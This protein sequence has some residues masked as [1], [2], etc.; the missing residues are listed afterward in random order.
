[1]KFLAYTHAPHLREPCLTFVDTGRK[2]KIPRSYTK[3]FII[4]KTAKEFSHLHCFSPPPSKVQGE[5]PSNPGI[6][7][8]TQWVCT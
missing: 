7:P 1:M 2:D 8:K 4:N 5:I 3:G 6:L